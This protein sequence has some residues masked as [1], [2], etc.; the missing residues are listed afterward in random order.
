MTRKTNFLRD[1]VGLSSIILA[2]GK[3]KV[4]KFL[5]LTPTFVEV[6]AERLAGDFR[7]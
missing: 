2:L 6:T 3:L 1:A 4:R 7:P 5:R